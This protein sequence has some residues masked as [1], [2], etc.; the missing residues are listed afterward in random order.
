MEKPTCVEESRHSM[1]FLWFDPPKDDLHKICHVY[2]D[3][4]EDPPAFFV[5]ERSIRGQVHTKRRGDDFHI[6]NTIF[7]KFF[8]QASVH[9]K[10]AC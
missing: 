7:V 9:R 8:S 3:C 5:S 6:S 4:Y 1:N 10:K 2:P